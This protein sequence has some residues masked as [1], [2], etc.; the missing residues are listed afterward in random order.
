VMLMG[1]S[2]VFFTMSKDGLLPK[3]FSD[4][5]PRYHT[6]YKSNIILLVF[7][8][9]FAAFVPGSLAGDLTSVG[10]LF[11]FVLVS[12][13]V[14]IMRRT[15]PDIHRPFKTPLVPLVPILGM[16]VCTV[17]IFS[18]DKDT[19]YTAALWL[20]LGLVLYFSYS[21]RHSRIRSSHLD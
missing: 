18:L 5:H 20:V 21:I 9:L 4:V 8:G 6:P 13:G 14:L 2:R 3:V 16:I 12:A 10:T 1:Q 15:E 11:A 17:M 19:L 7:V